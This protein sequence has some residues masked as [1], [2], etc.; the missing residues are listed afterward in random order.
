MSKLI[1]KLLYPQLRNQT[2]FETFL[3]LDGQNDV[4]K[5]TNW[6][7]QILSPMTPPHLK[8]DLADFRNI[9]NNENGVDEFRNTWNRLISGTNTHA[10]IESYRQE[11]RGLVGLERPQKNGE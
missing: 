2:P 3:I 8:P 10:I 11:W 7:S 5:L 1:E 4:E 9:I 6:V